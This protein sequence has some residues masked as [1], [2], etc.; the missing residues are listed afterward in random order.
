MHL[1]HHAW[2]QVLG[3]ACLENIEAR[4][5]RKRSKIS[6]CEYQKM[7]YPGRNTFSQCAR[8]TAFAC[9]SLP[10]TLAELALGR[11]AIGRCWKG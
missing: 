9:N 1:D 8:I 7:F 4:I 3:P 2:E 5:L 10:K 6:G 11:T